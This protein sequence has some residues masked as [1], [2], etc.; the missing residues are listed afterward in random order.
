MW[1]DPVVEEVREAREELARRAGYNFKIYINNLRENEKKSK[2]KVVSRIKQR[3][4]AAE[5]K[6]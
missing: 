1:K 6:I 3:P 5:V 2:T 4:E